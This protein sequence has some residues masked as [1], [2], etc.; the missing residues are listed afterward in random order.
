MDKSL[1]ING[2]TVAEWLQKRQEKL[3]ENIQLVRS[4]DEKQP[5]YKK[6]IKKGY[7]IREKHGEVRQ[8]TKEDILREYGME[9]IGKL[10]NKDQVIWALKEYTG[11][12]PATALT[13]KDALAKAGVKYHQSSHSAVTATLWKELGE[14]A[15]EYQFFSRLKKGTTFY[16]YKTTPE[17]D[18]Y[19]LDDLKYFRMKAI[20]QKLEAQEAQPAKYERSETSTV[21]AAS[22]EPVSHV[23]YHVKV[24]WRFTFDINLN[25]KTS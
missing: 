13:I 4:K 12:S 14:P 7:R 18:R 15:G 11:T 8:F 20:D 19:S 21:P 6:P 3:D 24:D 5:L 2:E 17:V 9:A 23:H 22:V 25:L 16:Y 1:T 10:P